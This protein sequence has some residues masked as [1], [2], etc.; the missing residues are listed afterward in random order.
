MSQ[1]VFDRLDMPVTGEPTAEIDDA[2]AQAAA[3]LRAARVAG[4]SG[5]A[6]LFAAWIDARL[7][8]RC[9]ISNPPMPEPARA[10]RSR[11]VG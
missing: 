1:L 4:D 2:L 8:A 6:G 5:V 10:G 7:D 3:Q 11:D 9:E